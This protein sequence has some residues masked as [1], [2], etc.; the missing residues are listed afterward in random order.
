[1]P[2]ITEE[3]WHVLADRKEDESIMFADIPTAKEY[4][5]D[6][7][8]SFDFAAEV[9]NAIRKIRK[10]KNISF[11]EAL[12]LNIKKNN[13]EVAD[14]RFDTMIQKLCN[15]ESLNYVEEKQE[16]MLSFMCRTT[17][18]YI[19]FGESIDVEAE[20]EKLQSDLKHQKGFLIGVE[21]KLSNERFVSGAPAKVVEM[22]KKKKADA[23]NKIVLIEEQ[24]K[25]LK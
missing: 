21:K 13:K 22:E 5:K 10:E 8:A 4:D 19:P 9:V 12:V 20:L 15:I 3:I 11:K 23:E 25:N 1:M 18:F 2:F 24:I 7:L 16:G 6:I 14:T 17:E